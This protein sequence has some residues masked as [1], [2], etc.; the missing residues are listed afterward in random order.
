MSNSIGGISQNYQDGVRLARTG[1]QSDVEIT[2]GIQIL[3]EAVNKNSTDIAA[4]NGLVIQLIKSMN[5]V[6]SDI[7]LNITP[8]IGLYNEGIVQ[9]NG[10][11]ELLSLL[12]LIQNSSNVG[13]FEILDFNPR[14]TL[15]DSEQD[16]A[17][18]A[19]PTWATPLPDDQHQI[20][21]GI[22]PHQNLT[23]SAGSSM[24]PRTSVAIVANV[25][26]M[27]GPTATPTFGLNET[28]YLSVTSIDTANNYAPLTTIGAVDYSVQY[29]P[30]VSCKSST[31]SKFSPQDNNNTVQVSDD[32]DLSCI[33]MISPRSGEANG[34]GQGVLT[35]TGI[36]DGINNEVERAFY[37][38][39]RV[40]IHFYL[41]QPSGT[42]TASVSEPF[43]FST[44]TTPTNAALKSTT[45]MTKY[46]FPWSKKPAA[47]SSEDNALNNSTCIITAT[48]KAWADD[49]GQCGTAGGIT[50]TPDQSF[51]ATFLTYSSLT[52]LMNSWGDGNY[53]VT[54]KSQNQTKLFVGVD[55]SGGT[56][57][58][59]DSDITSAHTF[60]DEN[61][62]PQPFMYCCGYIRTLRV[63]PP[64]A[65]QQALNQSF[66]D[67]YTAITQ[68]LPTMRAS[69]SSYNYNLN[70]FATSL[71]S[72]ADTEEFF[73]LVNTD[74]IGIT[75]SINGALYV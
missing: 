47:F 42:G 23:A 12:L 68:S 26:V 28:D 55:F 5:T 48:V 73:N 20:A 59:T 65:A 29:G 36:F 52:H 54:V 51:D 15:A 31:M 63:K 11:S 10:D 74:G 24:G 70:T 64:S 69:T 9:E 50:Y 18:G 45:Q 7:A 40:G 34:I 27:T 4:V 57:T 21:F 53:S 75:T 71:A 32:N 14:L 3:L 56:F 43:T 61:A 38:I 72:G 2:N 60:L 33:A 30:F 19:V 37:I 39:D 44:G 22:V 49:T 66:L 13:G 58:G 35:L 62:A 17:F 6:I 46:V 16:E 25:R 1:A 8:I 41:I 67:S